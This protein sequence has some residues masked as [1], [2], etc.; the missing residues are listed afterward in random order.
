ML[1]LENIRCRRGS[2]AQAFTLEVPELRLDRGELVAVTGDSGCGKS[3]LLE[4]LGLVLRPQQAGAFAW[5]TQN[6]QIDDIAALWRRQA[7]RELARIRAERIGFVLQTGGLLPYLTVRENIVVNRRLLGLPAADEAIDELVDALDIGHLLA[8]KP[9]Q[10]SIGERQRTAI[11]RALAHK[12]ALLLADEPTAALDPRRADAVLALLVELVR[13]TRTTT[14][15]ATHARAWIGQL[16]VREIR[17]EP[18]SG[19]FA[20]RFA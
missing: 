12:P 6:E 14:V 4:I 9:Q 5:H 11:G 17:A 10:L 8:K 20:S 16:G 3:T 2:G 1:K 13:H 18:G 15:I 19:G 7:Q